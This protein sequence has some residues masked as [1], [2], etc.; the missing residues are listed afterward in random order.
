MAF[1]KAVIDRILRRRKKKPKNPDAS[2]YP[3]F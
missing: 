2:I 3:M 1:I